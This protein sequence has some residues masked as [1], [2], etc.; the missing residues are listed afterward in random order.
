M[1]RHGITYEDV[2]SAANTLKGQ[3]KSITI[4][5]VRSFLGTGSAG[6]INQHLRRWKEVQNSTQKIAS[7]ENLPEPLIA[8]IKGLWEAVLTQ[9]TEQF[10]PIESNYQQEIVELKTELEKYR[11]NNQ[12][13]QKLFTQWQQEK[14]TLANEKLMLEQALEFALKENQSLHGKYDGL[15]QQLQEKQERVEELHRLHQQTQVNLENYREQAREQRLLDQQQLEREKQQFSLES[16]ELKELLVTQQVKNSELQNKN[17]LMNH[18][19]AELEK[20]C[21]QI[22]QSIEINKNK[23]EQLEKMNFVNIQAIQHWQN[24][25]KGLQISFENK[26]NDIVSLQ[27]ENKFLIQQLIDIRQLLCDT[28]NQNKLLA[29]E[30][31]EA[32]Q[33]KA[34]LEGQIL[35]MQKVKDFYERS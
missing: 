32:S 16:K 10:A 6:T 2:I 26:L 33:A 3:G 14:S 25:S 29:S 31:W 12:R 28:Q 15:L 23:I 7:K 20:H 27:S 34:Q 13:W 9:S 19:Y 21:N 17:Q 11:N 18:S 8:L 30:K 4:E 35:Q 1:A 24:Q 5:N 22:V